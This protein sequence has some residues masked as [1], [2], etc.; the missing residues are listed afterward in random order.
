MSYNYFS[1]TLVPSTTAF[2]IGTISNPFK[3]VWV[4]FGSINLANQAAGLT[5]TAISN[6]DGNIRIDRGGLKIVNPSN[7]TTSFLTTSAGDTTHQGAVSATG[8][9]IT[10]AG[11]FVQFNDGTAQFTAYKTASGAW[12]P[13]LSAVTN[14]NTFGYST[15]SGYYVKTGNVVHATFSIVLSSL[16]TASGNLYLDALP[17]PVALGNG[18]WGSLAVYRYTNVGSA[19][20]KCIT[21][22]GGNEG[23]STVFSLYISK[24]SSGNTSTNMVV[25]DLN[26]T[27]ALYGTLSYIS[28]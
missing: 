25:T 10:S 12:T 8:Y 28:T 11:G 4:S 5:G 26:A 6:T 23:T 19:G 3:D 15:Q 13:T 17:V 18:V 16:G 24:T 7:G 27:S 21:V 22:T 2:S 14:G 9:H 20:D 1:Q